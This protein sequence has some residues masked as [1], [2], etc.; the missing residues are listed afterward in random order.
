MKSTVETLSPT[1]VRLAIEVPFV[2]LEP[3]L[4]KAYREIGSQVQVPG[5]RRGKVPTAVI[6]QRVGRGTVLNE[7]VQEAIPENILAAVREHD[8]KTL[9]RPEVEITE[10]NDGDS[11]NFTAEVDVRPEITIPDA[12]SIEVTVDE[13]QIDESEIDEQVKNLRERFATLKTVE[14]AAAE[15][16]YVQIDL[17]ATVDG[18][19]V[20]GGQASNISHEVGSKQLLPGL[21]E[22]VVGL[23]AGDDTT[24]TT[25]LVGGDFAGR[26]A[27]VAVTVRTVK[28]KELP[29]LNDE[30]AQMASEFDT[31]EELRGDLRARVN[32]GKQ[33]EQIYAARDK[34]LAQLV[35]AA[36]IPAP[37]GVVREEVESRKQAMVDQLE[38]IGA[39]MEEYLAAE[40]KT[41]EQIDAELTEAATE[42]V[43]VQLLLDTLADA[44]DV[45]VSDDEFGHEIVH[46]AQ[47][48]GMAP[49]Q[50]YDQLVRSGAAAAVF[51]DVRRGKALAAVMER[52]TIKDSAGNEVTL[53]ALRA[54]NEAE[55]NHDH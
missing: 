4:K 24:F 49:Q 36:E 54:A 27:E 30:F 35:E 8:L 3:S 33:V 48:A 32:Q 38:R 19:D 7:A 14:R 13:L 51:G 50:Y 39:S 23:A 47:R 46:R 11:L 45:Q 40:D 21:D 44:E 18:E 42:G 26:D 17:N 43:K 12:S 1:R 52:I 34:A 22:A 37:E 10:F 6:D 2:E 28:E 29:E 25:Q 16:D 31:I 41:E 5:F 20:P 53:D 55:H 15:G 9:G